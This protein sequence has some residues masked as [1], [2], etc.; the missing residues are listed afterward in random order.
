MMKVLLHFLVNGINKHFLDSSKN[1]LLQMPLKTSVVREQRG[2]LSS[3]Q[4]ENTKHWN[5]VCPGGSVKYCK[6][7]SFTD[8]MLLL[9]CARQNN[10]VLVLLF[11]ALK[12]LRH[13]TW[14]ADVGDSYL[15]RWCVCTEPMN[16]PESQLI[17]IVNDVSETAGQDYW[18]HKMCLMNRCLLRLKLT[19]LLRSQPLTFSPYEYSE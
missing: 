3:W 2:T 12:L 13:S 16:S 15:F 6:S 1:S 10:N 18:R 17:S 7:F 8:W 9:A 14:N 19:G 5:V 4:L 11:C